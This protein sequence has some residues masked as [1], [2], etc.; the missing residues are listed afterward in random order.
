MAAQETRSPYCAQRVQSVEGATRSYLP[1]TVVVSEAAGARE[2]GAADEMLP[3]NPGSGPQRAGPRG[4]CGTE[5]SYRG[6]SQRSRDVHGARVIADKPISQLE[7]GYQLAN[8]GFSGGD[9]RA[10]ARSSLPEK[11]AWASWSRSLLWLTG[12]SAMIRARCTYRLCWD[13]RRWEFSALPTPPGRARWDP[14]PEF[15]GSISSAARASRAPAASGTT[16]VSKR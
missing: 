2:A 7:Q 15:S 5:N 16:T 1:K 13:N 10:V 11:P 4:V 9:Q 12:S 6:L 8:A 3:Q 14:E